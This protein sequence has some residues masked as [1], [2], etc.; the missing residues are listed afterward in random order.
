ML[1][2]PAL[3]PPPAHLALS[4]SCYH[5]LLLLVHHYFQLVIMVEPVE[6]PLQL[7]LPPVPQI[8]YV[9]LIQFELQRV[10]HLCLEVQALVPEAVDC[11]GRY[12]GLLPGLCFFGAVRKQEMRSRKAFIALFSVSLYIIHPLLLY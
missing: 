9:K 10:A 4:W 7:H 12:L 3:L 8:L 2:L 5:L 6:R 11:D 1:P